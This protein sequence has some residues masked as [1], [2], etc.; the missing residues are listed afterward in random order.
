MR[1]LQLLLLVLAAATAAH[2]ARAYDCPATCD[3]SP[4]C[5]CASLAP[6]GALDPADTPQFI[7]VSNDDAVTSRTLGA[8]LAVVG[9]AANR[10]GCPV[11]ATL[12]VSP[13]WNATPPWSPEHSDPALVQQLFRGGHEI[14]THSATHPYRPGAE[15]I[16]G[17]RAWLNEA[18]RPPG[19]WLRW[20][21]AWLMAIACSAACPPH[22]PAHAVL[23][24][25]RSG[26]GG[27]AVRS[28]RLP[29]A[30]PG[31]RCPAAGR[32]AGA[33]LPVR[34]VHAHTGALALPCVLD[35]FAQPTLSC[36]S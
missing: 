24:P 15:E 7:L 34:F 12:F 21:A 17:G 18:S 3:A 32:P 26:G 13:L 25:L 6:P 29:S 36:C 22:L 19:R 10:N 4:T 1:H 20:N 23:P 28:S 16:L 30:L 9:A 11:P 2:V 35:A 27:A 33:R 8:V 5:Q 31:A 14:A